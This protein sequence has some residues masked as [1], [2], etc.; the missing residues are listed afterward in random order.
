MRELK[1]SQADATNNQ[2]ELLCVIE[3][4][5]VLTQPCDIELFSDSSYVVK[6]INE[7]LQRWQKNG[8]INSAKKPVK[9][10]QLWQDY[11]DISNK[12]NTKA[13][14]VKAHN[15]HEQNERCDY[16]AREE[17]TKLQNK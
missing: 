5:K 16:L 15:G 4:M 13:T 8:W 3:A 6:A 11:L 12:H 10:K 17:A 14:W 2:M 9:N 7:W 1:G